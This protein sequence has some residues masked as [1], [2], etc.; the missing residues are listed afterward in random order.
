M[1]ILTFDIEEWF[2]IL[3]NDSTKTEK[4]WSSFESRIHYNMDRIF[5]IL[6]DQNVKATFFCLGWIADKYPDV[7]KKIDNLGYEI[8]THS[9]M[10]QLVYEMNVNEFE[11]D[12][13]RSIRSLEDITGK[14]VESYRAPGFSIKKKNLWA[15][16][17]LSKLGIKND[18]SVF[19]A[20]RS[21][22][23]IPDFKESTPC[24]INFNGVELKEFP[25]NTYN[26]MGKELIFSGGGYFR[27]M[28]YSV[29]K[30]MTQ[31]SNY[32]MTYFHPRDF[33][34]QQPMIEDLSWVRKF[35]SYYGL[36]TCENKLRKWLNDFEFTDLKTFDKSIDWDSVPVVNLDN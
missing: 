24:V 14:K 33:D 35:K 18:C 27:L 15:F 23:G 10:H 32:V 4:E 20:D 1:N 6:E 26:V 17:I 2:H 34:Y 28:P 19:P 13:T 31:K 11:E 30:R 21:H 25:I 5:K 9:R 3:D 29:V 7:I 36:K 8:G 22:G 12:L 16:E